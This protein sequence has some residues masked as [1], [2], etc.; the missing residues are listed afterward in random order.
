[1]KILVK[2]MLTLPVILSIV[3]AIVLVVSAFYL[4][5]DANK[6]K[7]VQ[8]KILEKQDQLNDE[9]KKSYQDLSQ[10]QKEIIYSTQELNKV[11]KEIIKANEKSAVLQSELNNQI[12]GGNSIP[13][14][15]GIATSELGRPIAYT[16]EDN[17]IQ[18]LKLTL[19]NSGKYPLTNINIT[20]DK[21]MRRLQGQGTYPIDYLG[22]IPKHIDYLSLG[23]ELSYQFLVTWRNCPYPYNY[24]V[25][26][27]LNRSATANED[28]P[29]YIIRES[30]KYKGVYYKTIEE[31]KKAITKDLELSK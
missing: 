9:L 17:R 13:L 25:N 19:T 28:F 10:A 31:L 7:R 27:T 30:Y 24:D 3:S 20:Y 22:T 2:E 11:Q 14:L 23:D 1:M 29:D 21:I 16:D 18:R 6:N 5:Y 15:S 12:T 26:A 8:E 4:Q